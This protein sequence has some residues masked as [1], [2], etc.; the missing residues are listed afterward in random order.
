MWVPQDRQKL[1]CVY[2]Q[3]ISL[4]E[5]SACTKGRRSVPPHAFKCNP[6]SGLTSWRPR[7]VGNSFHQDGPRF[8]SGHFAPALGA[9]HSPS[10]VAARHGCLISFVYVGHTLIQGNLSSSQPYLFRQLLQFQQSEIPLSR[11][12]QKSSFRDLVVFA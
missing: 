3:N 11:A 7:G 9:T 10:R 2:I 4:A 8:S 5:V 1:V 12:Q 6:V